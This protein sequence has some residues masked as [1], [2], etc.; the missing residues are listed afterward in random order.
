MEMIAFLLCKKQI[1]VILKHHKSDAFRRSETVLRI[2]L[3]HY[4]FQIEILRLKCYSPVPVT[5]TG[6]R[7]LN[8][9]D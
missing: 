1:R 9:N 3:K 7:Q 2:K 4:R 6:N 8:I 5:G